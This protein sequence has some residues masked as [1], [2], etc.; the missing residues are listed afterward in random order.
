MLSALVQQQGMGLNAATTMASLRRQ[1]Y[2][3]DDQ[4]G[5]SLLETSALPSALTQQR[6]RALN[7]ILAGG[8]TAGRSSTRC[9][10]QQQNQN[11]QNQIQGQ[12]NAAVWGAAGQIGSSA[13]NAYLN[14]R[15][16]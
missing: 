6:M 3:D 12:Q 14:N 7:Q 15:N 8:P 5:T 9:S 2:L 16:G 10:Q 11:Q 13:L 1:Q 4:R